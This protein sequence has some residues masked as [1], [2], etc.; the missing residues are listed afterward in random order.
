MAWRLARSLETLRTQ[1]NAWYPARSKISDGTIGDLRHQKRRSDHNPNSKGVVRAWD[2]TEDYK[3]GPDLIKLRPLLLKDPRV[4]YLIHEKL[5][6]KP[7]GSVQKNKGHTQHLHISVSADEKLYDDKSPW[8]IEALT[9]TKGPSV[10]QSKPEPP[11]PAVAPP[12]AVSEPIQEQTKNNTVPQEAIETFMSLGWSK[13]A[14]VCLTASLMWESGGNAKW[15]IDPKAHGDKDKHGRYKSHGAG[16]WQG[17]RYH[18]LLGFAQ[19]QNLSSGELETQLRFVDH[20]L[21]TTERRAGTMLRAAVSLEEAMAAAIAYWR[22]S[23]PHAD[24]RLAIARKLM[25]G[26]TS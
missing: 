9:A 22:P 16:Q 12:V 19:K 24:K 18:D 25:D 13:F 3:N 21:H 15:T 2:L 10:V 17:T 6:Y 14:A 1:I 4:K 8:H 26:G 7:D 20:E 11:K 23:K 5:L